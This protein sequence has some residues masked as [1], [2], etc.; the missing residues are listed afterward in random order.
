[1]LP[2]VQSLRKGVCS[3]EGVG[4]RGGPPVP[5]FVAAS[6]APLPPPVY[7]L[8][9]GLGFTGGLEKAEEAPRRAAFRT[10]Y[11]VSPVGCGT[12]GVLRALIG[13]PLDGEQQMQR[14]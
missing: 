10:L 3:P 2:P 12:R 9:W 4:F 11:C 14:G 8:D 6:S 1:M 13:C 5:T 7:V